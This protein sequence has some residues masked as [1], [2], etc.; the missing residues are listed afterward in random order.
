[1]VGLLVFWVKKMANWDAF[2]NR[3]QK[4][5][6]HW[7]KWARRREISC[8]RFYDRDLPDF[9]LAIDVYGDWLHVQEYDTNWQQ[10]SLEHQEWL[11]IVREA[12]VAVCDVAD[13]NIAIK[14]RQKQRGEA[15]FQYQKMD[16]SSEEFIVE[17]NN[18]HFWVNLNQYLDTGLFLDHRNA[19]Q[20][21]GQFAA[22]KRFLNLFAYTSSFTVYAATA[23]AVSSVSVDL[24]NTYQAWS[25]RNFTLN[26]L[27]LEK[28]RL[29]RSDVFTY[30]QQAKSDH[31]D[32]IVLDPP[33]FSNSKKMQDTLDVQRDHVVLIRHAMRLLTAGG[34]LFF[35]NNLRSFK[36]SQD[37]EQEYQVKNISTQTIP[38]DFKQHRIHQAW[39]IEHA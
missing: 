8:F 13:E 38:D 14:L 12:L 15:Q 18:R 24:S 22:G 36:L 25:L 10:T 16:I 17:E 7:K 31:F 39:W 34:K 28:H 26:K 6:K 11:N 4:N 19:R 1:M 3:L 29:I 2:I 27:D 32:L 30:L 23:G 9:P 5:W 20:L 33:T 35:S 37:I 21:I